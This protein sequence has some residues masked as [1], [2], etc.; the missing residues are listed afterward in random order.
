MHGGGGAGQ[1][2]N[3]V[4]RVCRAGSVEARELFR[5]ESYASVHQMVTTPIRHRHTHARPLCQ[6]RPAR[7]LMSAGP[8][9]PGPRDG[10]SP[11]LLSP[12]SP[13]P[14]ATACRHRLV[15]LRQARRR[16]LKHRP[17]DTSRL[18]GRPDGE[19]LIPPPPWLAW[20]GHGRRDGGA[21]VGRRVSRGH[22]ARGM[23]GEDTHGGMTCVVRRG[24]GP[25]VT[26]RDA[27]LVDG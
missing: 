14:V 2:R 27:R 22:A 17:C 23:L 12:L 9:C 24:Q 4:G 8:P 5:V 16:L 25:A 3:D 19:S 13:W 26:G 7:R 10:R 6:C 18:G 20:H 15:R 1:V 21:G 11:L